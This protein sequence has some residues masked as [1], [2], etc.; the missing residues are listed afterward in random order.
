MPPIFRPHS[1][2]GRIALGFLTGL[3]L[4]T[5]AAHGVD[6]LTFHNDNTHSG[7]N[8]A[9][10]VLNQ[11]NVNATQ[12]G[13][14]G[15]IPVNGDVF[16]QPLYASGVNVGGTSTNLL[17]VAT[18]N[19]YV[20]AFNAD[21]YQ[22]IWSSVQLG[23]PALRSV[24]IPS[25]T[26]Y[27]VN[28]GI[29]STPAIDKANG[30]V[31]VCGMNTTNSGNTFNHTLTQLNLATGAVVNQVN[32]AWSNGTTVFVPEKQGQRP[33][34]T[35]D[36][37]GGRDNLYI[38]FAS[39]SDQMTYCGYVFSY[40]AATLA[41]QAVFAV[42][43][44]AY[45][46][47]DKNGVTGQCGSGIWMSGCG[48]AIDANGDLLLVTGN[49]YSDASGAPT[50]T[51]NYGESI[52]RLDPTTLAVKDYYTPSYRANLN[53]Y[54][55]DLGVGGLVL[56]PNN[57]SGLNLVVHDSKEGKLY[58]ENRNNLGQFG[59]FNSGTGWDSS[60]IQANAWFGGLVKATPV[61]WTDNSGT[62]R[63]IGAGESN[64]PITAFTVSGTGALV[65]GATST[66]LDASVNVSLTQM[67]LSCN[68][69]PAA[70]GSGV[71]W[72]MSP[73]V[74]DPI[75]QFGP[76]I[77]RAYNADTLAEIY[78]STQNP[79]RDT[80]G[81]W[82][83]NCAPLVANGKV[84]VASLSNMVYVYGLVPVT[85]GLNVVITSP[86][87]NTTT[88]IEPATIT[89]NASATSSGTTVAKVDFFSGTTLI[90]EVT[91]ANAP[92]TISWTP[93]Y[94]GTY[95]I[96][97]LVTDNV[98][99]TAMSAPV[100]VTVP[101][102]GY[103]SIELQTWTGIANTALVSALTSDAAFP[104]SPNSTTYPTTASGPNSTGISD[105]GNRLI[106]YV[107]APVTGNYTFWIAS[108]DAS[109]LFLSTDATPANQVQIASVAQWTN[110]QDWTAYPSQQSALIPL[111]AGHRYFIQAL[112]A[113]GTGGDNLDVGW[114][115]PDGPGTYERPIAG[116]HLSPPVL[117]PLVGPRATSGGNPIT[118]T[119]PITVSIT[120]ALPIPGEAI[121]Y[122][123]D[124]VTSP[125]TASTL[126]TGPFVL[127]NSTTIKA[128]TVLVDT[129]SSA[130]V[131]TMLGPVATA[132]FTISGSTPYGLASLPP[133]GANNMPASLV[134]NPPPHL[135]GTGLFSNSTAGGLTPAPGI[136]PYNVIAPL[137]SDSAAKSRWIALPAGAQITFA[138][139]GEFTYPAGT[140]MIKNFVLNN[141]PLELRLLVLTGPNAGYGVTYKW[142]SGGADADL[143]GPS[144]LPVPLADGYDEVELDGQTWHYP[145]RAE[146]LQCHT[147]VANFVLGPKTR[148][149]NTAFAYPGGASDNELRTWNYLQMFTTDIGEANIGGFTKLTNISDTSAGTTLQDRVRSYVDANCGQCHRPNSGLNTYW[150]A[151]FDVPLA[152]QGIVDGIV[153][154]TLGIIGAEVVRPQTI[155]ESVMELRMNSVDPTIKMPPLARNVIDANAVSVL[156]AWIGS[157]P[158][159]STTVPVPPSGLVATAVSNTEID[160][161]WTNNANNQTG[162][163][164]QA[165]TGSG[166]FTQVGAVP[167][168]TFT[169]NDTGLNAGTQ[170]SFQVAASNG[171]GPSTFSNVATATTTGSGPGGTAPAA[172]SSGG[173]GGRCG[174]GAAAAGLLLLIWAM[175]RQLM[176]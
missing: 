45:T 58:V 33:A 144:S 112:H 18:E 53:L 49:G 131:G 119:G 82:P 2:T 171:A 113:Q 132:A 71:L 50:A 106:G 118:Y 68:G 40:N 19:N 39:F 72:L 1:I 92:Y 127:S 152:N 136:L 102:I 70:S 57:A 17:I 12:F 44:A 121:Y 35:L 141:V 120:S 11:G 130:P 90:G 107:Y 157:L 154:N 78:N 161:S 139:T 164:I 138:A 46:G 7:T 173:G 165:M 94:G 166:T 125:T 148:Q 158:P 15:T 172:S 85:P 122:T 60:I 160:L 108:D 34:L 5:P 126:Y 21:N 54:D 42:S 51:N 176:S 84:Y 41:Q 98:G 38:A 13:V 95:S 101:S 62:L 133:T 76:G 142:E 91:A 143:M 174:F 4:A 67:A 135:S 20:Y 65:K 129:T 25:D 52:V 87:N 80:F 156:D 64:N 61:Y 30:F 105:Y 8:A 23:T 43:P 117:A 29:T 6:V 116:G 175:R 36:Q 47:T 81:Y 147:A 55:T 83:K 110:Y 10:T 124:G 3:W 75:H 26:N 86:Q 115:L 56:L 150:N 163:V 168:S 22:P 97:A 151:V 114:Q 66:N 123:T 111:V 74:A 153:Q 88:G 155:S 73:T 128:V 104:N 89:I 159:S 149:L 167:G 16:A 32:L 24:V 162:F 169:F 27:D 9:E 170:Y 146:C 31:Y 69:S 63:V 93:V 137:W 100:T 140:V 48:P 79:Q 103:G 77:M 99:A 109:E 28:I 37:T 59:V 134:T 145:S 96:T 14:V